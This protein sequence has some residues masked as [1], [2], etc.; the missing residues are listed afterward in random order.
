MWNIFSSYPVYH[1]GFFH[2][3]IDLFLPKLILIFSFLIV[4]GAGLGEVWGMLMSGS[5]PKYFLLTI[6][7]N[8]LPKRLPITRNVFW[9]L[10]SLQTHLLLLF[11]RAWGW[12]MVCDWPQRTYHI[13]SIVCQPG[14]PLPSCTPK[15][16]VLTMCLV[17]CCLSCSKMRSFGM[18]FIR[19]HTLGLILNMRSYWIFAFTHLLGLKGRDPWFTHH[20]LSCAWFGPTFLR[21]VSTCVF[22]WPNVQPN[23]QW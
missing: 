1:V 6:P 10:A 7:G 23:S 20:L 3:T 21:A 8:L 11:D 13:W 17:Y 12:M 5:P 22:S 2:V 15:F 19:S 4:R 14:D 18:S 9:V 16:G